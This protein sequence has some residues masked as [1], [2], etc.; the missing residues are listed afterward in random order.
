MNY[1]IIGCVAAIISFLGSHALL[2]VSHRFRIYPLIRDRDVHTTPTPRLGG[3][4]IVLGLGS[5]LIA[6]TFLPVF[7]P[8]FV[9]IMPVIGIGIGILLMAVVGVIDD[10]IDLNWLVKLG[11]QLIAAGVLAWCGVQIVSLPFGFIALLSPTMSL[12]LTVFAVVLVMNAINFI[13]GLDGLVAGVTLIAGTVFFI[14]SYIL[15]N[16]PG[17]TSYFNL[18]TLLTAA[19]CGALIGFL[20]VNWHPAKMFMGDSGALVIGLVLAA[21]TILVTGQVDPTRIDPGQFVPAFIPLALPLAVLIV[22]LVDFVLAVTRRILNG[23]SPFAADRKHLHHRLLDMGHTHF[24]AVLILYAWTVVVAV[25]ALLF[26][27]VDAPVATG[28]VGAGLVV[29]TILTIAP[30]GREKPIN[31]FGDIPEDTHE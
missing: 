15:S 3:V 11:A 20:P 6:A 4:A 26:M 12:V 1:L 19:L 22:P 7:A 25:G 24:Q 2:R 16:G 14:Y 8:V 28:I 10:L 18:S 23:Q 29:T 13:D 9:N 30:L 21:S 27:F 31:L 5:A 17:Q